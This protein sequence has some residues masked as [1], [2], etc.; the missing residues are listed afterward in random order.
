MLSIYKQVLS[1]KIIDST[2]IADFNTELRTIERNYSISPISEMN[3]SDCS[4]LEY[5]FVATYPKTLAKIYECYDKVLGFSIMDITLGDVVP[6]LE[7]M[8]N[9]VHAR[10]ILMSILNVSSLYGVSAEIV[11]SNQF[12]KHFLSRYVIINEMRPTTC[13]NIL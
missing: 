8:R 1:N 2:T 7:T 6:A 13:C 12:A 3:E 5:Q 4:R 9:D 11:H 10:S